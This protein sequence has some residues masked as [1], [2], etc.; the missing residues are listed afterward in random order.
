MIKCGFLNPKLKVSQRDL[1][2]LNGIRMSNLN[3]LWCMLKIFPLPGFWNHAQWSESLLNKL[4]L[5]IC[6]QMPRHLHGRSWK[7]WCWLWSWWFMDL[8]N[9][10]R[11]SVKRAMTLHRY[12]SVIRGDTSSPI[13]WIDNREMQEKRSRKCERIILTILYYNITKFTILGL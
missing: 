9:S 4:V 11:T 2:W 10:F 1:T 13:I 6:V 5:L 7:A 8:W 12:T 3:D